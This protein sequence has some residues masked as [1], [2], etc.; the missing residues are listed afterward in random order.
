MTCFANFKLM[1]VMDF[2]GAPI[3]CIPKEVGSLFH[4][5]YLSLKDTKVQILPESIGKLFKLEMLNLKNSLVYELPTEI[6]GLCKLRY[7]SAYN[8]HRDNEYN[9]NSFRGIKIPNGIGRLESLQKL[10]KIEATSATL[11]TEFGKFGTIEEFVD[12]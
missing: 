9:I 4:L 10:F 7:L 5:R 12:L 1:K 6:S 11:I 2:E 3:D 8:F